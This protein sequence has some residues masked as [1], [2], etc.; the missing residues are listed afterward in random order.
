VH[1]ATSSR[2]GASS[3]AYPEEVEPGK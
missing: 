3:E 2:E 1:V